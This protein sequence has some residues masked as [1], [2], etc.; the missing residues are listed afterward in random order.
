ML[1][2]FQLCITLFSTFATVLRQKQLLTFYCTASRKI[3]SWKV[4]QS[5]KRMNIWGKEMISE[6]HLII[7]WSSFASSSDSRNIEETCVTNS[8]EQGSD[9]QNF[10]H[11]LGKL[12]VV[13]LSFRIQ[14][15]FV[16]VHVK[17]GSRWRE[18]EENMNMKQHFIG[19]VISPHGSAERSRRW[20]QQWLNI[21][22]FVYLEL[23]A[24][25]F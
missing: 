11:Q 12:E 18:T 8:C 16:N 24:C 21:V 17:S 23:I 14:N 6:Y 22:L 20:R 4:S 5:R 13:S 10:V 19:P 7:D 25:D 3:I 15:V 2:C 9:L 1:Q